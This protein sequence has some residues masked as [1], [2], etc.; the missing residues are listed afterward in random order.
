MHCTISVR[1][2]WWSK[3][4]GY[5][6]AYCLYPFVGEKRAVFAAVKTMCLGLK[7]SSKAESAH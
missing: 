2:A 1:L 4:L 5:A 7:V 6:V 3:P